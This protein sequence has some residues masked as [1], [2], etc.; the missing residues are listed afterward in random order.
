LGDL[1]GKV[2]IFVVEFPLAE[3]VKAELV[4]AHHCVLVQGVV[5]RVE[6]LLLKVEDL[7]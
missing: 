3:E 7:V 4:A 2:N 5:L 1:D 6:N